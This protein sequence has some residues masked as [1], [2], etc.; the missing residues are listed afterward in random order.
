M[1]NW[2]CC[3]AAK[4][5][6]WWRPTSTMS[7]RSTTV[8]VMPRATGVIAHF[9]AMLADAAPASA[10]VGRIGGEE[11]AVLL[12]DALLSDGRLHAEAVRTAFA[13]ARLPV[14]GVDRAFTASFGVAQRN[15]GD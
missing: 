4:P 15:P 6:C 7:S 11:F 5:R 13:S 8:S 12:P 10:I 1:A 3:A 9:A 2:R 14:L